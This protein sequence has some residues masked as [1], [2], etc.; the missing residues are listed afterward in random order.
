MA[1]FFFHIVNDTF[2]TLDQEGSEQPSVKAACDH[3]RTVIG[4]IIKDELRGAKGAIHLT[5]MI[6]DAD[7]VRVANINTITTI[8]ETTNPFAD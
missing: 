2:T 1:K 7:R 3:A 8:G 4:S 6:D 5:V